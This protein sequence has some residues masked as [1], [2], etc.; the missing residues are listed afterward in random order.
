[1][2]KSI[3]LFLFLVSFLDGQAQFS[4][5][6]KMIGGRFGF[7]L[8]SNS[9]DKSMPAVQKGG[10]VSAS[11]SLSKFTTPT[12]LKGVGIYY[13]YNYQHYNINNPGSEST[14]NIHNVGFFIDRTRLQPLAKKLYLSFTGTAG[15][16]L[17]FGKNKT[18]S[19]GNYTRDNNYLLYLNG[20]MGLWYQLNNR[21][22]L[23]G[24]LNNL[25]SI[26]YNRTEYKN[27]NGTSVISGYNQSFGLSTGLNGFS[28]NSFQIGVRYLLK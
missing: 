7:A 25:L 8:N 2:Q 3:L 27:Y 26:A 16:N 9:P 4:S 22:L 19:S 17:G 1:M 6:Q 18:G 14:Q 11:F 12:R 10:N 21:F 24:D 23:T 20:G 5:S 28:L 15:I 13:G